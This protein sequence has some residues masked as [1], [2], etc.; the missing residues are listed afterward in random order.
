[1]TR[2][3]LALTTAA[4]LAAPAFANAEVS[5]YGQAHLSL[6]NLNDG[7]Q[8][9]LYLN[10]NN[11][12]LGFKAETAID[13]STVAFVQLEHD[14]DL[15][16]GTGFGAARDTML[17]LH[18]AYGTVRAGHF[19][20]PMARLRGQVDLF[21]NQVGDARNVLDPRG[22]GGAGAT[23]DFDQRVQESLAFAT[24]ITSNLSAELQYQTQTA[25]DGDPNTETGGY[26][27]GVEYRAGA[28]YAGAAYDSWGDDG[29][30]SGAHTAMR[31]AA[32]YDMGNFKLVGL[33]HDTDNGNTVLGGGV[34]MPTGGVTLKAQYYTVTTDTDLSGNL[35]ALGGEHVLAKGVTVYANYVKASDGDGVGVG[36]F[37]ETHEPGVA[38]TAGSDS[39][40]LSAGMIV[41][42]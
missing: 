22:A 6:A 24:Q 2:K 34:A 30:I 28:L 13:G 36:A 18:T 37:D 27:A 14:V 29:V 8:S 15:V 26:S 4:A 21:S 17:G 9:A 3:L 11:S 5:L 16:D 23:Y 38:S 41:K 7:T 19:Y 1:M 35:L 12:F 20:T 42:F 33:Y 32:S 25:E 31:A 40:A 39:S 10:D